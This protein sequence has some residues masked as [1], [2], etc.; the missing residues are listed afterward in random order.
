MVGLLHQNLLTQECEEGSELRENE[1]AVTV[2]DRLGEQFAKSLEL[3]RV[4]ER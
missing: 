3:C 1:E 2:I 4:A